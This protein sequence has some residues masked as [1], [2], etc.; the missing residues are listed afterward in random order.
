MLTG[1]IQ[2]W[3]WVRHLFFGFLTAIALNSPIVLGQDAS[4]QS[5]LSTRD[6]GSAANMVSNTGIDGLPV[7]RP[8]SGMDGKQNGQ[9]I[10]PRPP[11]SGQT[12]LRNAP[13]STPQAPSSFQ[14]FMVEATGKLLP[15]FGAEFFLNANVYASP[16]APVAG[17]YTLGPGDELFIRISGAVDVEH[18]A[19]IERD[20]TVH[21]PRVG[22]VSLAGVRANA[23]EDTVRAAVSR[24]FRNFNLSVSLGQLRGITIYIVG[25]ARRPGT[26]SVPSTSTAISALFESSGPSLSGSMRRV[27]VKRNGKLL[28]EIDLYEFLGKGDKS[29]DVRLIDGDVIVMLPAFGFVALTGTLENQAIYEL[30]GQGDTL[31]GLLEVAGGVPVLADPRRAF[32]ERINPVANLPRSVEEFPLDAKGLTRELRP[33]DLLTVLPIVAEFSNAVTLRGS[34][35]QAV[36]VPYR[37]GMRVSDMIPSR[38]FLVTRN[39]L[40][41][42]NSALIEQSFEEELVQ[43]KSFPREQALL[44]VA[45]TEVIQTEMDEPLD[46]GRASKAEDNRTAKSGDDRSIKSDEKRA[47]KNAVVR[48]SFVESIGNTYEDINWEY[49]VVERINRKNLTSSLIPFNLGKVLSDPTSSENITLQPG[50]TISVFSASDVRIPV[51]KRR[52]VVRVEGEVR[53]PGVYSVEAGETLINIIE[54]AGG[55]TSDAYLFGSEFYRESV[56]KSQQDNLDKFVRRL[57]QQSLSDSARLSSNTTT[58]A[59]ATLQARLLAE[60]ESRKALIQRLRELKSSGRLSLGLPYTDAS[61]GQLPGFRLENNDHLII[62]PRPDF[63]QV[64]GSVNTESALLWRPSKSTSDY[65]TLS[66][67]TRDTDQDGVFIMRADGTVVTSDGSWFSSISGK[68]ILPGDIIVAPEKTDKESGWTSF[69][70]NAKDITQIFYNLGLGAAAIVTLRNSNNN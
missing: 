36:R 25:Q 34:I 12:N 59:A 63:V 33:G 61:L 27:Q 44:E 31:G 19:V 13:P 6:Q 24:V 69:V 65:L 56:R 40:R 28:K 1:V 17:D 37:E 55:P 54:K 42:Q 26:Y 52:V 70:R 48:K 32:L 11:I 64:F 14:K 47:V 16:S 30:K 35:N 2:G 66:G 58:E 10:S 21:I 39:Q 68:E 18:R 53:R 45:K 3:T 8:A 7:L 4:A 46:L 41:K 29:S 51:S 49:A 15:H 22:S 62:P 20:G 9:V 67:M 60:A 43:R 23:V 5:A 38:D 50:D 57:E